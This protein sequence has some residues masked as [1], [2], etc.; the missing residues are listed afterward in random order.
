MKAELAIVILNWNG[1]ALLE[2]FLPSVIEYS[3]DAAIYVIDNGST[4]DSLALL[5]DK[6]SQVTIIALEKNFGFAGGYNLGLAQITEP[7]L[8]LLNSDVRV[9][10]GWITDPLRLLKQVKVGIV[11]PKI[12]DEKRPEFF[13]YAGA[14]G[15]LLD[16]LGYPY[17]RGRRFQSVEKD[18]GQYE[19]PCSI[20]W[21]TGA[22]LFIKRSLFNE[23]GGF[24]AD[25]FAHQEEI[26]LC[27][28]AQRSGYTVW[29]TPNSRVYHLGGS[30]LA[31]SNP[32]KT[33]LNF[34]NSLLGLL[35]NAT[36][37]QLLWVIPI[38]LVLDGIAGLVFLIE[39]K[40]KHTYAILKAHF[41][42]YRM[43]KSTITKRSG[44]YQVSLQRSP[45]SIVF[46]YYILQ[47]RK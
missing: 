2:R 32:F 27:W 11:Q 28:R 45:L 9:E 26:D 8:C 7:Y 33:E 5:A 4:D 46:D 25:F 30:T 31:N 40:P 29:Y 17:C 37:K 16:K 41:G 42:F 39:G 14:A 47:K 24:D 23:L 43:F 20:F 12:L 6:F 34:R 13:E 38:R 35:K 10:K 19:E 21:A 1:V 18:Q 22:C 36:V 44:N 3:E 15:G